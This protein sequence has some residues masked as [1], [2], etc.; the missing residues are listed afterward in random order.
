M[1][2]LVDILMAL[3][4]PILLIILIVLIIKWLGSLKP[5]KPDSEL[6]EIKK[7]LDRIEKKVDK[8]G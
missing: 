3:L 2:Q 7:Q 6:E 1:T 4:I 5:P 8:S